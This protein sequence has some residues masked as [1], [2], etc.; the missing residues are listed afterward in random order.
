MLS[1]EGVYHEAARVWKGLVDDYPVC[2]NYR[3][4]Y[5]VCLLNSGAPV[6]SVNQEL[7]NAI[8][9]SGS[10]ISGSGKF[11]EDIC[12]APVD[13]LVYA[14]QVKMLLL[15][16]EEAL[17]LLSQF[18]AKQKNGTHFDVQLIFFSRILKWPKTLLRVL[19][20]SK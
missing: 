15:E 2:G 20:M 12:E 17:S 14:A 4:H 6:S 16:F 1:E 8:S 5:A 19:L 13:V 9:I 7:T 10:L 11:N 3:Y 18:N